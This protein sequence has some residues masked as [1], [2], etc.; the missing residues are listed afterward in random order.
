VSEA[1][2]FLFVPPGVLHE[3][4]NLTDTEPARA[5]VAATIR[6]SKTRCD[7]T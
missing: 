6:Q 2:E 1:D 5:V 7:L 3:A 4:I